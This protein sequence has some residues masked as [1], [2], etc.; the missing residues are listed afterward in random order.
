MNFTIF[1]DV[2]PCG[3]AKFYRRLERM[4]CPP[5]SVKFN[6]ATRRHIPTDNAFEPNKNIRMF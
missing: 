6:Q 5:K 2:T 1:M 4:Y 3:L